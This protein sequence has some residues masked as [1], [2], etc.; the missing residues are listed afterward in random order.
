MVDMNHLAISQPVQQPPL[1]IDPD[2]VLRDYG[3][4]SI[5]Q[6]STVIQQGNNTIAI[7][8]NMLEPPSITTSTSDIDA[9]IND[10]ADDMLGIARAEEVEDE[11]PSE[12]VLDDSFP[13]FEDDEEDEELDT[14]EET[15]VEETPAP[16]EEVAAPTTPPEEP[17]ET[18]RTILSVEE[19]LE[20]LPI[21]SEVFKIDDSTSR[22]SGAAWYHAIQSSKVI[23]AGLGGI[24][25]YVLFCLSRMKPAQ[26]FLYDDDIVETVN[27]SGQLYSQSM[28]GR[29]KVDAMALLARDFSMYY[30][31]V[32][33]PQRFT[34]QT[35]AGDIMICGFDNMEARRSFFTAWVNHLVDHPHPENCLFIDGRL[36]MEEFQVFCMKGDDRYNIKRYTNECLFMDYEAESEQC[37]MKQTTYCSNMIGSVIVNLFTNFIANSLHPLIDRDLPFKTYYDASMMYFKTET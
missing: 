4:D 2:E 21:N 10:L 31:I 24:G 37:S 22:F 13:Q 18:A 32:A 34:A 36:N 19:A 5:A 26:I 6:T 1:N 29:T 3:L 23:L 7:S 8:N 30:G 9:A 25:R 33:I 28:V 17:Q 35:E 14:E 11:E 15:P 27:L 20:L 12:V 16:Q